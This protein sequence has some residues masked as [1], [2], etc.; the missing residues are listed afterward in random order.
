MAKNDNLKDFLTDVADAIREKK[1]TEDLIN[2]Q[3]FADEIRNL[4][5]GGGNRWTGH[6]DVEGL[7]AI[8]WDDDDIAYYQQ[9]GVNWNEE[10]DEYHKVPDDNK[11][12][13][14]VLNANN[15]STYKERI[16]YLPKIGLGN[17]TS[18]SSFLAQARNLLAL[19]L[20]DTSK[21]KDFTAAFNGCSSLVCVPPFD[22]S[23]GTSFRMTFYGCYALS[24]VPWFD[25]SKATTLYGLYSNCRNLTEIPQH[26]TSN[27]TDFGEMLANC[28][29]I[30]VAPWFDTSKAKN[31]SSM[32]NGC[33]ALKIIPLYDTSNATNMNT[34]FRDCTS[35]IKAPFFNTSSVTDVSLML[36]GIT[37]LEYIEGLDVS[38][39]TSYNSVLGFSNYALKY[40]FIKGLH[41]SLSFS[42]SALF[43]K[44]SLLYIINNEAATEPITITLHKYAYQRLANSEDILAALANHPNVSLVSV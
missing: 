9:Y 16:V 18:L 6:A 26:N 39:A 15:I 12:L 36:Y 32:F 30:V 24:Y 27:T 28:R 13:Y 38:A 35:L 42:V 3:N 40:A 41:F 1:G 25:T 21:I 10:D 23:E 29:R 8:G 17:L 43:T 31:M 14:G 11:A 7:K 22:T 19:P 33:S 5:S 34:M 2:P 44:E 20:L 4:P 37:S